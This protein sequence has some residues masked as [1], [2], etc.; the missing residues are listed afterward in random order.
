[1]GAAEQQIRSSVSALAGAFRNANIRRLQLAWL[2]FWSADAGCLVAF[3]VYA[4]NIGGASAVGLIGVAR[5]APAALLAPFLAGQ[6]DRH[7]RE[8][9]MAAGL[10]A[11]AV[12]VV[13]VAIALSAG[14]PTWAVLTLAAV[15]ATIATTYWPAQNALIPSLA[16]SPEEMT[17]A[18][19]AT[20]AVE[21][22]AVLV[23]PALAAL[24]LAAAA[25]PWVFIWAAGTLLAAA[26]IA[27]RIRIPDNMTAGHQP[28]QPLLGF[29]H[30]IADG[31]H[32]LRADP[33]SR[34]VVALFGVFNFVHGTVATLVVVAALELYRLG[35]P[36]V[37][38]LTAAIGMGAMVGG[39]GSLLLVGTRTLAVPLG[40]AM[41]AAGTMLI[42][43][44]LFPL[45][46]VGVLCLFVHG[47][48]SPIADVA[49]ITL[50]QRLVPG[51]VLGRVFG[52][53]E[54]FYCGPFGIGAIAA[55]ELVNRIGVRWALGVCGA[56]LPVLV[57][58][59][60]PALRAIDRATVVPARQ[61]ALLRAIA[62]FAPLPP[63]IV[64]PL[65][66]AL[67]PVA[68]AAGE[69]A[70]RQG[71]S[72]GHYYVVDQGQFEVQIDGRVVRTLG[73]G[74]HF[75]EIALLKDLPRTAS[76]RAVTNASLYSLGREEFLAAISGNARSL[77]AANHI[78][79]IRL[80][81]HG[82]GVGT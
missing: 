69:F 74:D 12:L 14:W 64:E 28:Q 9:V 50:L 65:A 48:A 33:H 63:Q 2:C 18:N 32:A 24:I 3:G 61:I 70:V 80:Y 73:P 23:G 5:T 30:S 20:S 79:D 59:C 27:F 68:V 25:P 71:E 29:A 82:P 77:S 35:D 54:G 13:T 76:V 49:V 36:G 47:I 58:L 57:V 56:S 62:L 41:I 19:V 34:M 17:A 38:L 52:V 1:M 22:I 4:F 44:G 67:V 45:V 66:R 15:D 55:A 16:Q 8:R 72:G 53:V 6:L 42:G 37:G 21:G 43:P 78:A 26:G 75:G 81:E 7:P 60:L 51:E 11:R 39:L 31:L 46:A 40:L 10:V